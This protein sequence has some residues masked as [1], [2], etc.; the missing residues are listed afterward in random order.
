LDDV[1]LG[2]QFGLELDDLA[3]NLNTIDAWSRSLAAQ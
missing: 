1:D 2:L 3:R